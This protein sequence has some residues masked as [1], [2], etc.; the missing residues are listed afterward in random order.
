M[1]RRKYSKKHKQW[2]WTT[3]NLDWYS[4]RECQFNTVP[5]GYFDGANFFPRKSYY[6]RKAYS[7]Y[8]SLKYHTTITSDGN[9]STTVPALSNFGSADV[10]G[11]CYGGGG[12]SS[13]C[14]SGG[15]GGGDSGGGKPFSFVI[16]SLGDQY[17]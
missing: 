3:D 10:G 11:S 15:G 9:A 14:G 4:E 13:A 8:G 5:S 7:G 12:S 2:G 16:L 17:A 6:K 1:M